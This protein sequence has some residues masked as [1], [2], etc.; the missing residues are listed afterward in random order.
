MAESD[1]RAII[2]GIPLAEEPGLGA[3]TL[4]GFLRE[5]CDA[6]GPRDALVL[7]EGDRATLRWTY[8]DL[9]DRAMQVARALVAC[10]AGRDA[11]IGILMS[12]R[13][14]W[15]ASFFG[16]ALA[17][18]TAVG[19][20]TFSTPA[21]LEALI[22]A[23]GISVLLY[24]R[25]VL[26]KDF[27]AMLQGLEPTI[28][29]SAPGR[30][31]SPRFPYLRQ[32]VQLDRDGPHGITSGAIESW[33]EF[34]A[35]GARVDPALVEARGEAVRPADP[36]LLFF[37]S[38][39]TG[40]P[41]GVLNAHRGVN[42]QSWRW[43]RIYGFTPEV[44]L[45][46]WAPNGLFW[47]GNFSIALGGTFAAGGALILQRTFDP[48]EAITLLEK[49]RV[50]FAYC[51]PHQ[52]ASLEDT[53]GWDEADLSALHYF[54]PGQNLRHPQK[55]ISTPW[56]EPHATYGATETFTISAAFP[57][58][59]PDEV[60]KGTNGEALPG[61]TIKIVD[62]ET[63]A[64]LKRGETGEFAIK[65]PTLMLGY[66]G[67]PNDE[68]LDENGFYRAGDGGFIDERDRLIFQGRINDIIKTGGANV[69]PVEVDWTLCNCPGVKVCKTTGV[70]HATLG[71]M[72]VSCVVR[73]EGSDLSEAEVIGY[74]KTRLA[75][76]KV[77][78][79]VLFI[80]RGDLDFTDTAKIKP[81]EAKA[82]A[83][84]KL[85]EGVG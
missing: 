31:A 13:P 33:E 12:N 65:G 3:L 72:V 45:R 52:W 15:V 58:G 61:N 44:P 8:D 60:W 18:G 7:F 46:T 49:E 54:E 40:K 26:A 56:I 29:Q 53:P 80:E 2:H 55:T 85:A 41:K 10:G 82:F 74:L 21:E 22:Q 62:P 34:L 27:G 83:R 30:L 19:L 84:R 51:W 64:T 50:T 43:V 16:V 63:G 9:R 36:A 81:A 28:A 66:L 23:S 59:T 20:S 42:I 39:S 48:A 37:S 17:G 78:R 25:R 32:L 68:A 38:G 77:P 47:S 57:C 69:S 4:P 73:V 1:D 71:E 79:K 75:S 14:E 5:V 11:R 6:H 76:Y 67:I 24:E 35:H 70:P